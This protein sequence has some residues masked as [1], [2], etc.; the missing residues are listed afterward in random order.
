MRSRQRE[1]SDE[2]RDCVS[3][4]K[5]EHGPVR[6]DLELSAL[7][8]AAKVQAVR[9][10][11]LSFYAL[12][13]RIRR[14]LR[15]LNPGRRRRCCSEPSLSTLR[16]VRGH[17]ANRAAL[18]LGNGPS[19]EVLPEDVLEQFVDSGNDIFVVNNYWMNPALR[20]LSRTRYVLSDPVQVEWLRQGNDSAREM[21]AHLKADS[22]SH[23]LIPCGTE[24]GRSLAPE[25][26]RVI[27]FCDREV[28]YRFWWQA[29]NIMP[30]RPRSYASL[31]LLKALALSIWY[32]YEQIFIL[33]MDNTYFHDV[34]SDPENRI[35]VV[36]RH[37]HTEPS[38]V[39][40][41]PMYS[42]IADFLSDCCIALEDARK[43]VRP[44]LYNLDPYSLTDAFA[45]APSFAQAWQAL[46]ESPEPP[47][48]SLASE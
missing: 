34:R 44:N 21:L 27:E 15:E 5:P 33:G 39:D 48:W 14:M 29:T 3:E 28:R 38:L 40:F 13:P 36:N 20:G 9:K 23:I 31:T 37:A 32:Q 22:D 12:A 43:F 17:G 41:S 42:S 11:T 26:T 47:R 46:Y 8:P 2:V 45:K 35:L 10:K 1:L 24:I 30:D 19:Q 25:G 4:E 6:R 18:V 7:G 16:S